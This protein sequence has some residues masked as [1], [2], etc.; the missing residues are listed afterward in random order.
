[1][2]THCS[3]PPRRRRHPTDLMIGPV[4]ATS[5]SAALSACRLWVRDHWL[6]APGRRFGPRAARWSTSRA[7]VGTAIL[8][9]IPLRALSVDWLPG[10][11]LLQRPLHTA[12]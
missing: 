2:D 7:A 5:G 11:P 9:A 3:T 8:G 12:L 6:L 1:M 10:R 4:C